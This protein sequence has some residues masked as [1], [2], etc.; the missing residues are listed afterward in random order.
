[1]KYDIQRIVRTKSFQITVASAF[2]GLSGAAIGYI[3]AA[4]KLEKVYAAQAQADINEMK[5]HYAT[6]GFEKIRKEG[7]YADPVSTLQKI[8]EERYDEKELEALAAHIESQAYASP[9]PKQIVAVIPEPD[10]TIDITMEQ[11]VWQS[12]DAETYFDWEEELEKRKTNK[13]YVITK[14]EFAE[15][16][17]ELSQDTL[18]YFEGDEVLADSRDQVIQ[19]IEGL[20][21]EINLYRFGHGSDDPNVVYIRCVD[22]DIEL[23]VLR[24]DGK[25]AEEVLGFI[26][27]SHKSDRIRKFRRDDE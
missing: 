18:T 5:E 15:N 6:E 20:V 12:D 13:V 9:D 8:R 7:D 2:S 27:H 21:G 19:N 23:E 11:N 14:D 16:E 17:L 22:K 1:M 24:S 25:Y 4:K 10:P 26:E 3:Y